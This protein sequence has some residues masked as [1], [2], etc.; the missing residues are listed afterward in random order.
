M[1]CWL[2]CWADWWAR[3]AALRPRQARAS[4]ART[5]SSRRRSPQRWRA[6]RPPLCA[7]RVCRRCCSPLQGQ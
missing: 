7:R 2:A 3:S 6:W 4:F 5:S 1:R